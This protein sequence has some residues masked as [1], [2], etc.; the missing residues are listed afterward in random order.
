MRCSLHRHT[1]LKIL[2]FT[3]PLSQPESDMPDCRSDISDILSGATQ[4][5]EEKEGKWMEAG[6]YRV[7]S[8]AE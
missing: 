8:R 2:M 6:G 4:D 7:L 3:L 1:L 5:G